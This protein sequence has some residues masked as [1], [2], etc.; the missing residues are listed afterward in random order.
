MRRTNLDILKGMAMACVLLGHVIQFCNGDEYASSEAFF[1]NPVYKFIYSFHLPVFAIISGYLVG[2][3]LERRSV[4]ENMVRKSKQLLL[5]ILSLML[6][7]AVLSAMFTLIR[8]DRMEAIVLLRSLASG[9][10]SF[11]FL[12][13]IFL[14]FV[15]V[16]FVRRVS[17]G[18]TDVLWSAA[19]ILLIFFVDVRFFVNAHKYIISLYMVGYFWYKYRHRLSGI[20]MRYRKPLLTVAWG[21]VILYLLSDCQIYLYTGFSLC[22]NAVDFLVGYPQRIILSLMSTYAVYHAVT[23]AYNKTGDC[24]LTRLLTSFSAYSIGLYF[25]QNV[26]FFVFLGLLDYDF[27]EFSYTKDVALFLALISICYLMSWVCDQNKVTR[28]LALGKSK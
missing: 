13:A 15:A 6:L 4:K 9:L 12:W 1:A 11:W 2:M 28:M 19:V 14:A 20:E 23:W 8:G 18:R 21:G 5:P 16:A 17:S 3:S 27:G 10:E 22:L 7:Y 25:F 24:W 26:M